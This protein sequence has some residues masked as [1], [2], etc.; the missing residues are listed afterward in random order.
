MN[1]PKPKKELGKLYAVDLIACNPERIKFKVEVRDLFLYAVKECGATYIDDI[2]YQFEP[3]GVTGIVLIAESHFSLH[4]WPEEG[5]VSFDIFTCGTTMKSD[6][7]IEILHSGFE[8]QDKKVRI[9]S[10]GY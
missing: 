2:F 4:T 5:Y 6:T 1:Q 9:I 10:R 8:A 7:A 3:Y